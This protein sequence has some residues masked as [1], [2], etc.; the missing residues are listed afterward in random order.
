MGRLLRCSS[1]NPDQ[2]ED[3][4]L[5][6]K[7]RRPDLQPHAGSKIFVDDCVL[8]NAGGDRPKPAKQIL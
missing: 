3:I 2:I 1:V 4:L 7:G 6:I 5:A 8:V